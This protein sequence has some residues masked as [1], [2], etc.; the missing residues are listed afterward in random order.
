VRVAAL[1]DIHGNLP[2]LAAV[3]ADVR[4]E[5]VDSVV[6]VGDTVAGPWPVEVFDLV[7]TLDPAMVRGNADRAVVERDERFGRNPPWCA[8]QLGEERLATVASWPLTCEL[9][10]TG[11]GRV[12]VCHATPE[13]DEPIYTRITPD[14][15]LAE[16]FADVRA[17]VVLCGHT[18]VQYD[19]RLAGGLRIVNAG[20]VGLPYEGVPGA[21][22]AV[23][24]PGVE[25]RR[26]EYDVVSTADAIREL[27]VP[28]ERLLETLVDPPS[29]D[30]ATAHF[31][32]LRG[33]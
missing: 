16:L 1:S 24:G 13:S 11:L 12:L 20:S 26:T 15:E 31:E 4:R 18:H 9:D 7:A 17:D 19:R 29:A 21:Y 30:E 10:I 32:S 27:D 6:I 33:A 14:G 2:A 23:L 25:M 3:L 5:G 22:W 28:V 8:D